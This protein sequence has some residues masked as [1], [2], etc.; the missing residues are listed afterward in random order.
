MLPV[1]TEQ[2]QR[3]AAAQMGASKTAEKT[4]TWARL[5]C[6]WDSQAKTVVWTS[7]TGC[8]VRGLAKQVQTVLVTGRA[9]LGNEAG[10]EWE[11]GHKRVSEP[12]QW[13]LRRMRPGGKRGAGTTGEEMDGSC[14]A[15][16][17]HRP[18]EHYPT[19]CVSVNSQKVS[20]KGVSVGC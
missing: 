5:G 1:D 12:S 2:T 19:H 11:P 6:R 13:G 3:R 20:D 10:E 4:R 9:V 8:A 14:S 7:R 18:H 16:R 15:S 17:I